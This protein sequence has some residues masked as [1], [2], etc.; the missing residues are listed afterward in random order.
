MDVTAYNQEHYGKAIREARRQKGL[1][2]AQLA[3]KL[4]I[5]ANLV[6]HWEKG[7]ARP[8]LNLVP[9]L[10]SELGIS[11]DMFFTGRPGKNDLSREEQHLLSLFRALPEADRR[12][13]C[14][15]L[16]TVLEFRSKAFR[17]HCRKDFRR[18]FLNDQTA[19]AGTGTV[20]DSAAGEAV[21]V[22]VS[23][24][25]GR[26]REIIRVNGDSMFP[27]FEDG[28]L[29]YVE[30]AN[31]LHP[32]EIGVFVVNGTGYIKEY[33]GDRLHSI[34]PAYG[35]IPL[36][37]EDDI[38]C[39]GR[40]LGIAEKEDFPTEEELRVLSEPETQSRGDLQ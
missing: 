21:F 14:F 15:S 4:G 10:C 3:E 25:S 32:G 40:V 9:Q 16:E 1:L 30:E 22:R 37:E 39:F 33:Q 23:R 8:D 6:G 26:A 11:L 18:I 12:S 35:D 34:N 17:E 20:L 2:Q 19:A 7:R 31:R 36:S 24:M 28:Q 27:T 5:T 29:V 13:L 38:R